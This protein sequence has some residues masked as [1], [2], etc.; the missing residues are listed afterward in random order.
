MASDPISD[1]LPL[2]ELPPALRKFADPADT[3]TLKSLGYQSLWAA[4][5]N[6][7]IPAEK[8]GGRWFVRRERLP[9]IAKA[10]GLKVPAAAKRAQSRIPSNAV[11]V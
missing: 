10:R 5:C 8:H 1:L 6:G 4:C 11:A 3:A 2:T 9:E 7:T